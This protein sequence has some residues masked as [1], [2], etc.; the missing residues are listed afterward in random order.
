[1][2]IELLSRHSKNK[3][4]VFEARDRSAGEAPVFGEREPRQ[5]STAT[6]EAK[7]RAPEGYKGAERRRRHRRTRSDRRVE[8]RFEPDKTDRRV[9]AGRRADDKDI[10]FW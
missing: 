5:R 10:K 7:E 3:P 2:T 9:R 1:M 4:A 8:M 6:F